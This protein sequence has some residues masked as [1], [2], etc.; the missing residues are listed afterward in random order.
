MP[1]EIVRLIKKDWKKLN[2]LYRTVSSDL[3]KDG[4]CQ[5]DWFYPNRFVIGGDVKRGTVYGI[6][7]SGLII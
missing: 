1:M 7:D 2:E 6:R 3:K 4:V 5:W